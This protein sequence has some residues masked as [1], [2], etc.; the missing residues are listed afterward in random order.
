M[1]TRVGSPTSQK[2]MLMRFLDVI[3]GV[4][5]AAPT[6]LLPVM[7]IPLLKERRDGEGFFSQRRERRAGK[8]AKFVLVR[9]C[10]FL[11]RVHYPMS[12]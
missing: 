8:C 11:V 7:K 9:A 3:R 6:K 4:L 1:G 5:T 12:C 10:G 2:M